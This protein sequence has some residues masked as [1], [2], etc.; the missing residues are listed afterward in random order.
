LPVTV[1]DG[2]IKHDH[3]EHRDVQ[4]A[5]Q[6]PLRIA[7]VAGRI[8]DEPEP[9]VAD[10]QHTGPEQ[11]RLLSGPQRGRQVLRSDEV[12]PHGGEHDQNGDLDG[13]DDRFAAPHDLGAERIDDRH[14]QY[15]ADRQRFEQQ[16][17]RPIG[18]AT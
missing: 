1:T 5:R 6:G 8:G 13:D 15:G 7:H 14:E 18:E 16:C 12:Q 17:R 4:S 9:L 10:E 3:Q 11:D 2:E